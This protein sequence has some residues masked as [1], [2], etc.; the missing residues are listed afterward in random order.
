MP[1]RTYIVHKSRAGNSA[2]RT[3]VQAY[4]RPTAATRRADLIAGYGI[5]ATVTDRDTG[6]VLYTATGR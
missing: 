6:A 3:F 1:K 5:V 4:A 2:A